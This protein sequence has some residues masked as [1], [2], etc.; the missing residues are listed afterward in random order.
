MNDQI[1]RMPLLINE[2]GSTACYIINHMAASVTPLG[3]P[4]EQQFGY[5]QMMALK[6][7]SSHFIKSLV[8][9]QS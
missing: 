1:W 5:D 2:E 8:N 9:Y 7:E 3:C 4:N 6:V